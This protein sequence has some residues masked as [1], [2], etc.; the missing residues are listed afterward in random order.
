MKL[1]LCV[2]HGEDQTD[3]LNDV[4]FVDTKLP[5]NQCVPKEQVLCK[6]DLDGDV[7]VFHK[8]NN[9]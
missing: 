9:K 7:L 2:K 1:T 6:H 3:I 4:S 8:E 5:Y